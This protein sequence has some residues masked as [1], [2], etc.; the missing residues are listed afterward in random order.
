[1]G[2]ENSAVPTNSIQTGS[3]SHNLNQRVMAPVPILENQGKIIT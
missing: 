1:M 2:Y 3:N